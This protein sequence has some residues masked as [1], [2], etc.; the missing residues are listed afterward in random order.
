MKLSKKVLNKKSNKEQL[1]SQLGLNA[2]RVRQTQQAIFGQINQ[3]NQTLLSDST[4]D[5]EMENIQF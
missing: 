3:H 5:D 1:A 2:N 4:S